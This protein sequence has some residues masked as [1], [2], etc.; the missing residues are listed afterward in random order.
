[1]KF[2]DR[3]RAVQ[4]LKTMD[5]STIKDSEALAAVVEKMLKAFL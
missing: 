5:F 1:V 3:M 2:R 4:E